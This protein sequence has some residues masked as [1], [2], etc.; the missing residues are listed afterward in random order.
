MEKKQ[1]TDDLNLNIDDIPDP[2]KDK[3][4]NENTQDIK[5][6]S[7]KEAKESK[8]SKK[9]D[10][11]DE[12][13]EEL[14]D[15][16]KRSM[17]EFENFRKRTEKE[18]SAMYDMGAKCIL[19]K[20][21]Q[22]VDNFERGIGTLTQEQLEDPFAQGVDKIYKQLLTMLD[23]VNVKPIEALEKEFNPDFHN[24]VMHVED[25]DSEENIIIEEFQKGYMYKDSVLRY[26][27]VKVAN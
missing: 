18:K 25:E 3:V 27:M 26:S 17:A 22:I 4:I 8:K 5:K 6:D 1:E 9:K 15:K 23:E 10:K 7:S 14:T 21:L 16:L 2:E 20:L 12:Q 24:A 11:K 19:E 13:I